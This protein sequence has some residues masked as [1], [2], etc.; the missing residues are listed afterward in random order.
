MLQRLEV[1]RLVDVAHL[2]AAAVCVEEALNRLQRSLQYS[3]LL[4][5]QTARL[6]HFLRVTKVPIE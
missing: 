2:E 4:R 1:V 3:A 5:R 6:V